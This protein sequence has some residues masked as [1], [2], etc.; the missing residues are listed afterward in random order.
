MGAY[1]LETVTAVRHWTP[2]LFSFRTTRSRQFRFRS[3]QFVM[4]GIER[5]GKRTLRAYSVVSPHYEDELEFLSIKV[6]NGPLTSQ[7]QHIRPGDALLIGTKAT[8]TLVTDSLLPGRNLFLIGTGTGLAPF[9]SLIRDPD[10]Y[11]RF[12]NVVLVHGVRNVADLAYAHE[13]E[14]DLPAHPLVGEQATA[15]LLYFPTVTREPFRNRG[16]VTQ[17]MET[18]ALTDTLGLPAL[19]AAHD[20]VMLCGSPGMLADMTGLLDRRGFVEGSSS[21]PASYVIEKAFVEK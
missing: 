17:Q 10:V 19:D 9:L 15:Q 13:I 8:G 2:A 20:R 14:H 21:R 7:L 6:A 12:A 18:G 11:E 4:L 16:R 5:D 1:N 3:G